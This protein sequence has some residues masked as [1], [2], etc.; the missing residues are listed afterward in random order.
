M[1]IMNIFIIFGTFSFNVHELSID[2][3]LQI[4]VTNK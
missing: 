2:V 3:A 1:F 4:S